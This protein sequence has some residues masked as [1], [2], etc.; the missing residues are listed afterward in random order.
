M[1][2]NYVPKVGSI[3][4]AAAPSST[5]FIL[6][7]AIAGIGAAGLLQGALSI[8]SNVVALERRPAFMGIVIGVFGLST[9]IGPVVGGSFIDSIGWQWCFWM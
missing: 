4:C 5:V 9:C 8:I 7:R 2:T 6:G 3:L 1:E